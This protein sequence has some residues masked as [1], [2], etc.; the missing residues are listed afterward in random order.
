VDDGVSPA[1]QLVQQRA[2]GD[3]AVGKPVA[4]AVG[5]IGEVLQVAGVGEGIKIGNVN[6]RVFGQQVADEVRT[7]EPRT[8]RDQQLHSV[9][10][11]FIREDG[12][13]GASPAR[14]ES[15][16]FM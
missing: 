4:R 14:S 16:S 13:C 2:V 7:D 1:Q 15:E 8:S 10:T 12:R 11:A 3:V 9:T 5:D 6:V